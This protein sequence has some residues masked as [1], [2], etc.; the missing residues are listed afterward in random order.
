[1][2]LLLDGKLL[3]YLM[4]PGPLNKTPLFTNKGWNRSLSRI[5]LLQCALVIRLH[6]YVQGHREGNECVIQIVVGF[7]ERV[8]PF[9]KVVG[10]PIGKYFMHVE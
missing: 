4:V 2:H 3:R 1:M 5:Q 10:V 9:G 6:K 8:T 7:S